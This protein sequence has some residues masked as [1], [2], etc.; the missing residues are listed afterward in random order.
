MLMGK[1]EPITI[2]LYGADNDIITISEGSTNLQSV[3]LGGASGK[4]TIANGEGTYTFKSS[5]TSYSTTVAVKNGS[6]VNVGTRYDISITLNGFNGDTI[7]ISRTGVNTQSIYMSSTSKSVLLTIIGQSSGTYTFKSNKSSYST[8]VTVQNGT[9]VDVYKPLTFYISSKCYAGQAPSTTQSSDYN[10]VEYTVN[11][12]YTID[13][14]TTTINTYEISVYM[15]KAMLVSAVNNGY[16]RV[17]LSA[18]GEYRDSYGQAHLRIDARAIAVDYSETVTDYVEH[19]NT[20]STTKANATTVASLEDLS[21]AY[22]HCEAFA[23]LYFAY[24]SQ[25]LKKKTYISD[26]ASFYVQAKFMP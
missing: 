8:T 19:D 25:V 16:K 6:S 11:A 22:D 24:G 26:Y 9:S 5:K 13:G 12:D 17:E 7:Y 1:K 15:Y 10:N 4:A 21:G 14:D 23:G 2:T 3:T 18:T 20:I